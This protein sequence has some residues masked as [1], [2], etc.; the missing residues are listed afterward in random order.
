MDLARKAV[1]VIIV[2]GGPWWEIDYSGAIKVVPTRL[3]KNLSRFLGLAEFVD[4]SASILSHL[5]HLPA[6]RFTTATAA[7]QGDLEKLETLVM[8]W[9]R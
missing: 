7:P 6:S 2:G 3:P 8:N 1:N 5:L 9:C 4:Q